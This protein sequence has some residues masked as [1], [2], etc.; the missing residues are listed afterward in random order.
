VIRTE[1][2]NSA[3]GVRTRRFP[4]AL[5]RTHTLD[6]P[7]PIAQRALRARTDLRARKARAAER[8]GDRQRVANDAEGRTVEAPEWS[9]PRDPIDQRGMVLHGPRGEPGTGWASAARASRPSGIVYGDDPPD[10][11][12]RGQ[13][14]VGE[15][16]D[17]SA[18]RRECGGAHARS[19]DQ[20]VQGSPGGARAEAVQR[21]A[22]ARGPPDHRLEKL[23]PRPRSSRRSAS[24]CPALP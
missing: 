15:E 6:Q 10:G 1:T 20:D 5:H 8:V 19:D 2:R 3:W 13:V 9:M 23:I 18:P 22:G 16:V 17:A 21:P 11:A 24:S 12:D 14:A 4:D 7:A